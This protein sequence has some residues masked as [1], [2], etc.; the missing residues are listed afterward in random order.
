MVL[1]VEFEFEVSDGRDKACATVRNTATND[2]VIALRPGGVTAVDVFEIVERETL[3][4]WNR[5]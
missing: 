1:P 3:P 5:L 4:L 2:D